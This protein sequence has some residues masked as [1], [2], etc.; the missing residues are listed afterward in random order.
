[1]DPA[2]PRSSATADARQSTGARIAPARS[3]SIQK[4]DGFIADH[5]RRPGR[6][7]GEPRGSFEGSGGAQQGRRP[8]AAS[9]VSRGDGE[10]P[11]KSGRYQG[12]RD[13]RLDRLATLH[14]VEDDAPRT[15]DT[16]EDRAYLEDLVPFIP[17]FFQQRIAAAVEACRGPTPAAD[18]PLRPSLHAS[19]AGLLVADVTGFTELTEV[20]FR[21]WNDAGEAPLRP[22]LP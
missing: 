7:R 21:R 10:G 20:R 1:M 22:A 8:A 6:Q 4:L 15:L 17:N 9:D 16:P 13:N 3:A 12:K 5:L 18:L 14:A 2:G 11:S 19:V